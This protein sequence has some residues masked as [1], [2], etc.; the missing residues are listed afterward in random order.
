MSSQTHQRRTYPWRPRPAARFT[1]IELLVV[2]AII[3]ILASMLLP[4]ITQAR[5]KGRSA[6]CMNNLKQIGLAFFLYAEDNGD[7][8][9]PRSVPSPFGGGT[10]YAKGS[11]RRM[12]ILP[13]LQDMQLFSCP[14]NSD[15]SVVS[16]DCLSPTSYSLNSGSSADGHMLIRGAAGPS[17]NFHRSGVHSTWVRYGMIENPDQLWM[18]AETGE[19]RS[20]APC[21]GGRNEVYL[22][23]GLSMPVWWSQSTRLWPLHTGARS[24]Y[25]MADH[26]VE[27]M[28][29]TQTI[30]GANYW[31]VNMQHQPVMPAMHTLMSLTEAFWTY[32]MP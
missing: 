15:S 19:T 27:A 25:L 7:V 32:G 5:D 28:R 23:R 30:E 29:P 8:I 10:E 4:A 22:S 14:S 18:I 17:W 13:I 6:V 12:I 31:G 24:N 21:P 3:A 20:W 1:L 26:H 9:P 16:R 2:I 11:W